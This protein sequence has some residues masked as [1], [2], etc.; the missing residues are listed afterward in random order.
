MGFGK[1]RD[2]RRTIFGSAPEAVP[3]SARPTRNKPSPNG[4]RI[5]W[6]FMA[7]VLPFSMM[8]VS[9]WPCREFIADC[10]STRSVGGVCAPGRSRS[11]AR[12]CSGYTGAAAR[13]TRRPAARLFGIGCSAHEA[14]NRDRAPGVVPV[15]AILLCSVAVRGPGRQAASG[16]GRARERD[17]VASLPGARIGRPDE[18][19]DRE[20]VCAERGAVRA[21]ARDRREPVSGGGRGFPPGRDRERLSDPA[22]AS[23]RRGR[24]QERPR[25]LRRLRA[26][27]NK[28]GTCASA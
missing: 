1:V 9:C 15:R 2:S 24:R 16:D 17:V 18:Q 12:A 6:T 13:W 5:D 11:A 26:R 27:R 28:P 22:P 25:G 7:R 14:H 20:I 21:P 23:L 19:A 10:G 8:G 3:A 4:R